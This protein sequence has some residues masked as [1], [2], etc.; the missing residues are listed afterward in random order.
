MTARIPHHHWTR[1]L[2]VAHRG[3]HD[4]A[5]GRPENSRAAFR[6]AIDQGYAIECDVRL[7]RDGVAMVFHDADLMRLCGRAGYLKDHDAATLGQFTLLGTAET[8]PTLQDLLDM[9]AGRVPLLIEVKNYNDAPVGPLESAVKKTLQGYQGDYALQSFNPNTV[10]WFAAHMPDVFRGQIACPV[11]D[12]GKS[13][14]PLGRLGLRWLLWRGHGDPD[15]V[16]YDVNHLPSGLTRRARAQGKPAL[17][18]TVKT[19]EQLARARAH[20]DNV[21]FEAAGRP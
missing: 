19:P 1:T 21:I 18:W 2:P 16:A 4:L 13:L 5:A 10:A 20:A 17:T 9:T 14:S 6:A 3:L 11:A 12:M 15:F 7:S 8:I